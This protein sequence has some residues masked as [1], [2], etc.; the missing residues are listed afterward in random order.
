MGVSGGADSVVL[1][2]ALAAV[3]EE[4]SRAYSLAVAHLDH[5]LRDAS[6]ADAA[7]VA[8][9][10]KSMH[11]PCV[12]EQADVR[13]LAQRQGQGVEH[14][15]RMARY[16]FLAHAAREHNAS[17]VAVAHH[18][19]D[20][21]ETILFRLL[22]GTGMRGLR[23][24]E[25][26]RELKTEKEAGSGKP[27]AGQ[28]KSPVPNPQSPIF[29]VRPLL[30][31]RREEILA[32]ARAAELAWR[33]DHTNDETY[34]RRNFLRHELLPLVRQI[35]DHADEALLRLGEL[36]GRVEAFLT[37]QAQQ[38]LAEAI[39]HEDSEKILLDV[40][41]FAPDPSSAEIVLRTTAYRLVLEQLGMPQRDLSAEHL[42]A[43]DAL[44]Q[45]PAGAVNL[46][47]G[48]TARRERNHLLFQTPQQIA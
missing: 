22:R 28:T 38:R 47:A 8:Q 29:L 45:T 41:M 44:L 23:G 32:Y 16:E 14:A 34:Y 18:A 39:S 31:F 2:H 7:F 26:R 4:A 5:G 21:V 12:I 15:A 19:D 6:A 25:A 33:E 43:V 3:A 10:A 48:F 17:A 40:T 27:A 35:N 13:K 37:R 24:M 30:G 36:A 1:L 11:L 46:P 20:N 9:L 42:A